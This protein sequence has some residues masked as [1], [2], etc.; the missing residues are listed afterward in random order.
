MNTK[1]PA[2]VVYRQAAEAL[3][4]HR[5]Q[6]IEKHAGK[7][8]QNG[9]EQAIEAIEKELDAGVIEEVIKVAEG[10]QKLAEQMAEWKA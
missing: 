10:E 2:G 8:G 6:V 7:D 5:M 4:Q 9:G 1:I 3:T